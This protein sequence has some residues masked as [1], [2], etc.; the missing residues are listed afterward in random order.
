MLGF[1]HRG[2]GNATANHNNNNNTNAKQGSSSDEKMADLSSVEGTGPD[3]IAAIDASKQLHSSVRTANLETSLR[4]LS[5][6][7]D[8]NY[9][10]PVR[11]FFSFK[12]D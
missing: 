10:H 12:F 2:S 6:G 9:L 8:P 5:Y 1:V 7:A 3:T 11:H 4:L